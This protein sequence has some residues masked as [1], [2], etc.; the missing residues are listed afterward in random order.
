M[1][2]QTDIEMHHVANRVCCG[3]AIVELSIEKKFTSTLQ[4]ESFLA[5]FPSG[6]FI[7]ESTKDD[8]YTMMIEEQMYNDINEIGA[9]RLADY[10]NI[11]IKY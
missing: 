3:V 4:F 9:I 1:T 8:L 11:T 5:E 2:D 7:F 10:F 6:S